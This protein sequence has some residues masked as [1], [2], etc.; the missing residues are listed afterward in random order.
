[1]HQWSISEAQNQGVAGEGERGLLVGG[2]K[3]G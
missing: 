1:M 2:L 3:G